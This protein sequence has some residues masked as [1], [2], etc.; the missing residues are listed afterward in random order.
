MD[1]CTHG[2]DVRNPCAEC[3][4]AVDVLEAADRV[5]RADEWVESL[6][7]LIEGRGLTSKHAGVPALCAATA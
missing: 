3:V 4:A 1:N 5:K 6:Y 7:A 2:V